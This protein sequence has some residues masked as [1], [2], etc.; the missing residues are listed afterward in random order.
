MAAHQ[1]CTNAAVKGR[2]LP[3]NGKRLEKMREKRL[4]KIARKQNLNKFKRWER[5]RKVS[6]LK[7]YPHEL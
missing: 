7:G 1:Q 3:E 2:T 4:P 6:R 5:V